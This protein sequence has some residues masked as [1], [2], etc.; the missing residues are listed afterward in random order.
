[1]SNS[2]WDWASD[3]HLPPVVMSPDITLTIPGTSSGSQDT[4]YLDHNPLYS[5]K[6]T[7]QY[8][9]DL[10]QKELNWD[11]TDAWQ[12]SKRCP[13]AD[14]KSNQ[15]IANV[16][17]GTFHAFKLQTFQALTAI[18]DFD[19]FTC[20]AWRHNEG[21]QAYNSV[22]GMHNNIH[23][24]T[25]TND[26]VLYDNNTKLTG[27]MTDV[28]ASSFDPVFWLHHVNCDRITA[29]WQALNPDCIINEWPSLNDRYVAKEGTVEGGQSNLE[30]WH[31]T[32]QHSV[33]DYYIAND[34]KE[35]TSTFLGGYY[36]PETP[37]EYIQDP[38]QMK[39]YTTQKIYE[40]YAPANLLPP[41]LRDSKGGFKAQPPAENI[42]AGVGAN[43][44][45]SVRHWQVFLRVKNFALTGTWA[46]HIFLGEL[47]D[48][49][50]EWFLSENRVGTVTML[51]NRSKKHCENCASQEA[52]GILVT[53]TVPLNEAL[54]KRGVDVEN[55]D[56]VVAFLQK[57]LSWRAVKVSF[58]SKL[59]YNHTKAS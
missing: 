45:E 32:A 43:P 48:A 57:E 18:N 30:P 47:P 9:I 42:P 56:A 59:P 24:Y 38:V 6:F 20:Q 37:L 28:Q 31:K 15:E 36:Y 10:L 1:M 55:E 14:G 27:N 23:N 50:E 5:Y 19:Q 49:T 29:L 17:V 35:L 46:V 26:T 54:E 51:S 13:D 2:Y 40:L 11:T 53:G 16:Q 41:A 34:T 8:A 39:A 12:E 22:E 44:Q 52:S 25:G 7:S 4:L 58:L 21:P 3:P 33:S